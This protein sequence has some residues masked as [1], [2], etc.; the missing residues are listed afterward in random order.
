M[1]KLPPFAAIRAFE[2]AAR[3]LSFKEAAAELGLTPTAVSHQI[4]QLEADCDHPLFRR[5][6][7]QVELTPQGHMLA[8]AVGPA[9][10]AIA[11]AYTRLSGGLNRSSVS[12]ATGPIFASR[13]LVPRL[14]QFWKQHPDIDLWIHHSPLPV[15]RQMA[16]SDLAVAW[17]SGDWPGLA[18]MPLLRIQVAP[19]LSPDFL[20]SCRPLQQPSEILGLPLLHY[21]SD[22]GWRQWLDVAGVA[23][24]GPLSGPVFEDANVLLQATLAGRGVSLGIIGFVEDEVMSGRLVQPFPDR[25]DPGEAY[26]LVWRKDVPETE[27]VARVRQWLIAQ[28]KDARERR[29]W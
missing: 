20:A 2:A 11:A 13:W 28:R 1:R 17:G 19:V 14:A 23:S 7:R 16:Q 24:H 29:P 3:H 4:R 25:V 9:L 21:R 10:D 8:E 15:W 18:S 6:V 27:V 22:K 12:L 5:K 26:H